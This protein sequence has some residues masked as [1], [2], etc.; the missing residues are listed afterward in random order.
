MQANER[1]NGLAG[2][3][4]EAL[5][6]V[7]KRGS[8]GL[9]CL[10]VVLCLPALCEAEVP[11]AVAKEVVAGF[12]AALDGGIATEEAAITDLAHRSVRQCILPNLMEP[13]PGRLPYRWLSLAEPTNQA[14]GAGQW[15]WDTMFAVNVLAPLGGEAYLRDVFENYWW[16]IDHNSDAPRGSV[17]YGMV[18]CYLHS[19][20]KQP[21]YSQIP[22][23][24]WGCW[25]VYQQNQD[26]ALI[27]RALP[28]LILFD[29]WYSSE[30]DVNG[31]GLIEYGTYEKFFGDGIS[32]EQSARFETFDNHI[33]LDDL[34]LTEHPRRRGG[35]RWYGDIEGVEQTCFLIMQEKAIARLARALGQEAIAKKYEKLAA[36]RSEA[37]RTK[38]W[39]EKEGCFFSVKRDSGEQIPVKTIQ[40]FLTMTAGVASKAQARRLVECLQD[41]ETWWC[42][43]PVPTAALDEPKFN[44][45]GFWRGDMWPPTTYLVSLGLN[46]YGYYD[47]SRQ[48]TERMLALLKQSGFNERYDGTTGKALGVPNYCWSPCFWNMVVHTRYGLQAGYRTIVVPPHAAGRRLKLGKIDLRYPDD[49][50]VALTCAFETSFTVVFPA[51]SHERLSVK[52]AGKPVADCSVERQMHA[53]TF[54]ANAGQ[55]YTVHAE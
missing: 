35:G 34:H 33:T 12:D 21:V 49:S 9:C 25:L 29:T 51:K 18:P 11:L 27:E 19:T 32:W 13:V 2:R 47:V 26:R 45:Q 6:S 38:M 53:I 52:L 28:Y 8:W 14:Y 42:K 24:G 16:Y 1:K 55:T 17:R 46:D 41:P 30:R 54:V 37:V 4:G 31:N 10:A 40:G 48:L 22:I 43:Y 7:S 5:F 3:V 23:L 39:N 44:P 36:W 50:T 15:I 20:W